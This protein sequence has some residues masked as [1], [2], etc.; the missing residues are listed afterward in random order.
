MKKNILVAM[1]TLFISGAYA[2]TAPSKMDDKKM[3]KKMMNDKK[4]TNVKKRKESTKKIA[5]K[6]MTECEC[7]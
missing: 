6:P 4:M 1:A 3:E 7:R 2:Q 5:M